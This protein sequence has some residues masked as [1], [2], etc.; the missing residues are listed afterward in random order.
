MHLYKIVRLLYPPFTV[1]TALASL[2][3][4]RC[5]GELLWELLWGTAFGSNFGEQL[6]GIAVGSNL[7]L[8]NNIGEQIL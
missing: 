2:A 6:W 7:R 4:A 3:C 1:H 8:Y 5:F